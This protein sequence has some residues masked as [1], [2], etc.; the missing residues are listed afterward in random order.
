MKT[1]ILLFLKALLP[2]AADLFATSTQVEGFTTKKG[3]YVAPHTAIR[4]K[5]A[6][7]APVVH[8]AAPPLDLFSPRPAAAKPAPAKPV[9]AKEPDYP[10]LFAPRPTPAPAPAPAAPAPASQ[11]DARAQLAAT[12]AGIER[13]IGTVDGRWAKLVK[14]AEEVARSKEPGRGS[15]FGRAAQSWTVRQEGWFQE[16][17]RAAAPAEAGNIR[18]LLA[19]IGRATKQADE[20]AH[21]LGDAKP[22]KP[23]LSDGKRFL[24][25]LDHDKGPERAGGTASMIAAAQPA[26]A[27]APGDAYRSFGVPA[28]ISKK[29]RIKLNKEARALLADKTDAEMTPADKAVLA[30]YSGTGQVGNSLNEFYT[31]APVASAVWDLLARAGF[32]GGNVLEPSAGTGVFLH[33]APVGAKVTAV[34]MDPTSSRIARIL[35]DGHEVHNSSLERFATQ[36]GATF[37]AVV[38]NPPFGLRGG[39]IGDDKR[40]IAKAELYFLDT[41]L[42]KVRDG[43]LVA[44]VVPSGV[45]DGSNNRSFR[46]DVL[47]KAE[48]L[49]ASRMPNTA[50]EAA[51]TS[52]VTDV[53][54]F[55]KRPQAVAGALGELTQDQ[56]RGLGVWDEDFLAGEY[57]GGRGAA[58][59]NGRLEAGWREKAGMGHDITVTGSMAGVPEAVA[60][61]PIEEPPPGPDMQAI[62]ALFDGDAKGRARVLGA[63]LRPPYQVAKVGD[64]K[65]VDGVN[66]V[67]Q[68]DPPRWHRT[69]E[70]LHP[71]VKD[72]L[73][74][75]E[76][77][78]DL[79]SERARDPAFLRAGLIED[80]DAFVAA[81]GA[82]GKNKALRKW[83]GA[84]AMPNTDGASSAEHGHRVAMAHQRA[85]RLLGAVNDDGTYSDLV[86]GNKRQMDPLGVDTAALQLSLELGGFTAEQLADRTGRDTAEMLDHLHASAAYAL[87]PDGRTWNTLDTYLSGELWPKLDAAR[88]AAATTADPALQRRWAGQADAL[89]A[90]IAPASLEDVEILLSSGFIKPE[91]ITAWFQAE[92][93][94]WKAE[95]P[96]SPYPG[97]ETPVFAY[98]PDG[99][100]W[101]INGG[102]GYGASKLI[103]TMLNRTGVR[104]DERGQIDRLNQDFASWLR[105]SEHREAV[106]ELYNRTYRG[107]RAPAYSDAPIEIPGINPAPSI[108]AFHFSGL[109]WALEAGS[110][111]VAADVGLG[112]TP[113]GLMLNRLLKA[114][115]SAKKPAI[116]VPKSV[117]ANWLQSAEFW[118]PGSKVMV[119][120]ET[121]SR[122]KA[123]NL[124][125][126]PDT[127]ETK[128]Q[129]Y[130]QLQQNDYDFVLISQPAWNDLDLSPD[131]KQDM[132]DGEFW[133]KRKN[134]LEGASDKQREKARVQFDQEQAG[135]DF[136]EREETIYFDDL[137]IDAVI[138]DEGHAY[139]N[140]YAAK[141]RFGE[142]PKFLGGSGQSARAQ[143]TAFKTK[144]IRD[145]NGGKGVF[146]LT[147]TPT[148][149]SPLE[150]YS[151]LTHIAPEAFE[152]MGIKNSEEFLDR[153][154]EFTED[155]ILTPKG[156]I[157]DAVVTSGF[158]NLAELREVMRRYIDRKTA[159]DVGLVIPR[160]DFVD[161]YVDMTPQQEATYADLREQFEKVDG[162]ATGDAHVFSIMSRMGKA[163]IDLSLL[164][165]SGSVEHSPKVD[166]CVKEAV[167]GAEEG[168]QIIF[169]DHVD[170]HERV[171][172]RLVAAGVPRSQIGII[173][174]VATPS[175]AA[176]Q[177]ICDK[178]NKGTIKYVLGNTAT[179]GE[180]VNLQMGTTDIHH[181]D[182]PW[183][184]ASMQQR[185]GRG[186]RQGNIKES[187]RLHTYLAKRSFD[188]YRAQ[189]IRAKRDWQDL[190]WNGEDRVEN[191]AREGAMT[192]TE[193]MILMAAD[194][195]AARAKFEGDKAA[196]TERR[197]TEDRSKAIE[198][199]N[200]L[201]RLNA[202]IAAMSGNLDPTRPPPAALVRLQ[203]KRV[204]AREVLRDM[205]G[206]T[207]HDLLDNDTPHVIQG[208][209]GQAWGPGQGVLLAGGTGGPAAVSAHDT[210]WMVTAV[211]PDARTVTARPWGVY[212]TTPITWSLDAMK[213]GV[214]PFDADR[215]QTALDAANVAGR[216]EAGPHGGVRQAQTMKLHEL[217]TM[218]EATL[219][220]RQKAIEARMRL[221][222]ST[223]EDAKAGHGNR[224]HYGTI[225]PDGAPLLAN[226]YSLAHTAKDETLMLPLPEHK[227]AAIRG[228]V[229]EGMNRTLGTRYTSNSGRRS[230]GGTP[231]GMQAS[232]T[233][234]T[235]GQTVNPWTGVLKDLWG[236]T[237][238]TEA[239]A[240]LHTA[241]LEGIKSADTFRGAMQAAS[242]SLDIPAGKWGST[243]N[244]RAWPADVVRHLAAKARELGVLDKPVESAVAPPRYSYASAVHSDLLTHA[245]TNYARH[246]LRSFL[247][248]IAHP[249]D[250]DAIHKFGSG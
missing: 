13:D 249:D 130:H 138:M 123:G 51:H 103:L 63:S 182:L 48:F 9:R 1:S 31:P 81:H 5:R 56:V 199:F 208:T 35:H 224:E 126:K 177:A 140:L 78:D 80:L 215:E 225:G 113:R 45:M 44:L 220:K 159:A 95:N 87:D 209:T 170:M 180:G 76:T 217:R 64:T 201:G 129:K 158:K 176:R 148:K 210:R 202:G 89:E 223:F 216:P 27:P 222:I 18:A 226:Q 90:T 195:D 242:H 33:T 149:N 111:I 108:N 161:H 74:I 194:P 70:D 191:L 153:F 228:F 38:G 59:V 91:I 115:G 204:Q 179:M 162:D 65:T 175:G 52:V 116:V 55:R 134:S 106:E 69:E 238:H 39:V 11:H 157:E 47:R 85:A 168:G 227:E 151:M 196:A 19:R 107:Y 21:K 211:D 82:P 160:G 125:S 246:E 232:Y 28:G 192:K 124:K 174:G 26:P 133:S 46:E 178:F 245:G 189:T 104:R 200:R 221:S 235:H 239:K 62:L 212:A 190:L 72:A 110:G 241:A 12:R 231:D 2:G 214:T 60:A 230:Y 193:Q 25:L 20:L 73:A 244:A 240:A 163:S 213:E 22:W 187:V 29:A 248:A 49:G 7:V 152:R 127:A 10:D 86:T 105:G 143:D 131:V 61:M 164:D 50:F 139:K 16:A 171:A 117:L 79:H 24:D 4:H 109:R 114:T 132:L 100:V 166:A 247:A 165:G 135:K 203:A 120:G 30:Q 3:T 184:P 88:A 119:I 167:K 121:Y 118:F 229:H 197:A 141:N 205:A 57:F 36:D 185:N 58:N 101:S 67:L 77:L 236:A 147:A 150:I 219:R 243:K 183:E 34:E 97:P 128:R 181:L 155:A 122:D 6:V 84:P 233:G 14:D 99:A 237:A 188:G 172:D 83:L 92:H 37:D 15:Y 93:D 156:T 142:S 102:S 136:K 154:C 40:D 206:F 23:D 146:M 66:Y 43:G 96:G 137:G 42:D 53:V 144:H 250:A 94:T 54:L 32:S 173:N 17:I 68:G 145:A 71:A 75:A 112:K 8:T 41:A 234:G 186:V 207:H 169:C 218:P 98:D 198:A